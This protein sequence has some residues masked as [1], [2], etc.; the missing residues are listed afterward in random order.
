MSTSR[1]SFLAT[2]S[3][4]MLTPSL[5]AAEPVF[6]ED[7]VLL[8]RAYGA[9][10]P[11]L[12]RY[13]SRAEMEARF[14]ALRGYLA[15]PRSL[16]ETYIAL[17]RITASVR[18]G[19]SYP[20]FYNQSKAILAALFAG[21]DRLPFLFT[22]IGERM[23]VTRDLSGQGLQA[24]TEI[25]SI[26]GF[27]TRQILAVLMPL[28]RADGH[29]DAKRRRILEVEGI[30]RYQAFDLYLPMLRPEMFARGRVTVI[31]KSVNG[32]E[33]RTEL[34]LMT[35][36]E[37]L[38]AVP[39]IDEKPKDAVLWSLERKAGGVAV[40][41]MPSWSVYNG[42]WDWG[43]WLETQLDAMASDGTRCLIVDLRGNEGGL[44]CG[45]PILARLVESDI[46]GATK[47][48]RVRYRKIPDDIAPHVDTWDNSFFDWGADAV[49]PD[50][51][52][53]F[54]LTSNDGDAN[55]AMI[56][57]PKGK[58]LKVKV[59]ALIDSTN[60][61]A[62]FGFAQILKNTGLATLIGETTGGNRRGINGGAFLFL[63]LPASG[64]EV[65][66]PL[67]GYFPST[68]EPDAGIE[69]DIAVEITPADIAAG[70]DRTMAMALRTA[71]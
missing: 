32:Q 25:L 65:D 17:A 68:P 2:T 8:E 59:I 16:A 11:G 22:W 21:R 14:A 66:I 69:P 45:N 1:R 51:D 38:A 40:L 33:R 42:T 41:T 31:A 63:R 20:N 9:L 50:N 49:G 61:S 54:T 28:A 55:G 19:H 26:E 3:A 10:H 71:V 64:I 18:C 43:A 67:I 48:R 53:F 39:S 7:A 23:I 44:D 60:S 24:G 35:E 29:N 58:R 70:Y 37:R 5:R 57:R 12:Y 6:R 34:T 62:T 30:D 47:A 27:A 52:G 56:I 15:Q 4:L 46:F 36:A 13:N